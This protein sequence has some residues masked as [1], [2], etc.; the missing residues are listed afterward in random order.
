M[1]QAFVL[2]NGFFKVTPFVKLFENAHGVSWGTQMQ[3]IVLNRNKEKKQRVVRLFSLSQI[4]Q[5]TTHTYLVYQAR[6]AVVARKLQNKHSF[7][8][9]SS[10]DLS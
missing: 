6:H 7:I 2:I 5:I 9:I 1:W 3:S 10:S 4:P 8:T